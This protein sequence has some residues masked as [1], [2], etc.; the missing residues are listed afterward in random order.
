MNKK[1]MIFNIALV[2]LTLAVLTTAFIQLSPN[3]KT[4]TIGDKQ[5]GLFSLYNQGDKALFYVDASAK[6]AAYQTAYDLGQRGGFGE[7]SECGLYH[8]YVF[9]HNKTTYCEPKDVE[10]NFTARFNKNL[11]S[12]SASYPD[13]SITDENYDV[14]LKDNLEIT[15]NARSDLKMSISGEASIATEYNKIIE[16]ASAKYDVPSALIKAIIR[17]ESNF[18]PKAVS[19]GCG[20]A[21]LMQLMPGTAQEL[22]LKTYEDASFNTCNDA[23]SK[24]LAI[25]VA[26]LSVEEA[27]K[28]DERFDPKKNIMAGT[29]HFLSQ[30]QRYNHD[31]ELSTAAYN[32]GAGNINRYCDYEV[33]FSTC[34]NVPD[35]TSDYVEKVKQ[36][37]EEYGQLAVYSVKPSFKTNIDYDLNVYES[38]KNQ[39]FDLHI[40]CLDKNSL[41]ECLNNNRPEG[42]SYE[43]QI[44]NPEK[45]SPDRRIA[46]INV[47]EDKEVLTENGFQNNVIKFA[48]YFDDEAEPDL[49]KGIEL[50][51]EDDSIILTWDKNEEDDIDHYE[52]YHAAT[53]FEKLD[54]AALED[55][56][57][58]QT[59]SYTI[60][61][62]GDYYAVVA[63]D[64]DNN[65]M[66]EGLVSRP[67]TPT[68]T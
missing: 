14:E 16:R 28:I 31:I 38:I 44:E 4:L 30:Y 65:M 49:V 54:Q 39:A 13:A 1:A 62:K 24:E 3:T 12:Y 61:N 47:A 52:I 19:I 21:G 9:W 10:G 41:M 5:A 40:K 17:Q 48:Y 22:G 43:E 56:V 57:S 63:V 58:E 18:N 50:T 6:L 26:D 20:A 59:N 23:Y 45:C 55:K 8:G 68:L 25:D 51:P 34:T 53:S 46:M 66:E 15:G 33:G 60:A 2:F 11:D 36:Y 27:A 29:K 67:S 37:Y 7:Q 42:W 64:C 35:E 32:W